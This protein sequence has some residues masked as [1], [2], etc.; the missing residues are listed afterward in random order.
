MSQP[1][2]TNQQNI[3]LFVSS[4]EA[5]QTN[6]ETART[7]GITALGQKGVNLSSDATIKTVMA[8]IVQIPDEF[9][10]DFTA[11]QTVIEDIDAIVGNYDEPGGNE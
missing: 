4:L 7:A 9:P 3:N 1:P 2:L 6:L 11:L 5:V 10:L 8:S